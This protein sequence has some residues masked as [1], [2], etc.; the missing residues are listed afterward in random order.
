MTPTTR[1]AASVS[2]CFRANTLARDKMLRGAVCFGRRAGVS[3]VGGRMPVAR[4]YQSVTEYPTKSGNPQRVPAK[5]PV[6]WENPRKQ[7]GGTPGDP[8][9]PFAFVFDIDGVLLHVS[10]PIPGAAES[11][12]FLKDHNIPFILL[13]NG[14]GKPEADRV[15]DLT[16]KLGVTLTT[17]NFVQSHTPFRQLVDGPDGFQD[18][19]ILVTG[20]DPERCRGIALD[21]GFKTV[22]TPADIYT[23]DP[24]IFPFAPPTPQPNRPLPLPLATPSTPASSLP[25]HLKI[26]AIFVFDDPRDWALDTQLI[27]DLL[28]SHAGHLGTYSPLNAD[29]SL[30]N[31]GWQNDGQPP[32]YLSNSDLVWSAAYPLPRFG[33]GAFHAAL[34]GVWRR[35]TGGR[36]LRRRV[37]G[38]PHTETYAFAER[39]LADHRRDLLGEGEGVGRLESVYMVGDNPA[40]DVAGANRYVSGEGTEWVSVLVETGV[41]REGRVG[42]AELTGEKRPARVVGDV[43]AAVRAALEREG[44]GGMF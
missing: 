28:Q 6:Q 44:W 27:M 16:E 22:L 23:A 2:T 25:S 13:T 9:P 17:D 26:D 35:L 7:K 1:L 42:A 40:S 11:L 30:P 31:F 34:A 32:L 21:Y 33:Q 5:G 38:K 4:F 39:V 29:P 19:T 15:R 36:A 41:W 12:Q 18:K 10:K 43:K 24:T 20:S 8:A 14:G 37:L 3:F